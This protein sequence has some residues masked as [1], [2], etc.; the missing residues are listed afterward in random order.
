[1]DV[2]D[3]ALAAMRCVQELRGRFGKGMV[4]DVLRGSQNAKLLDMHLDEAACYD[5]GERSGCAGE[6]SDRAAG[7]RRLPADYRGDVPGGGSGAAC[8][9]GCRRG[10]QLVD[11]ARSAKARAH[12][13]GCRRFARVRLVGERPRTMPTPSC[14]SVCARCASAWPTKRASS[15]HRVLRCGSARYVREKACN[16]RGVP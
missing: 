15:L 7:C 8:P 3:T 11:E 5:T 2:T 10:F 6:R 13:F 9:R 4:V 1:M 14:S 16:R 12:A